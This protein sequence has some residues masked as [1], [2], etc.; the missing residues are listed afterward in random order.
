MNSREPPKAIVVVYIH[1]A[2]TF[3]DAP[4]LPLSL[5]PFP[6]TRSTYLGAWYIG[7][8]SSSVT[9]ACFVP[10]WAGLPWP[11]LDGEAAGAVEGFSLE[12]CVQ[13]LRSSGLVQPGGICTSLEVGDLCG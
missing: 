6:P 10:M 3:T 12:R 2:V 1:R 8:Q 13:S 11:R 7:E 4:S 9:P 5:L